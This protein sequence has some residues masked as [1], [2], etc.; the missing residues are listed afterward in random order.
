M[1]AVG[2]KEQ[3]VVVD[4]SKFAH[5]EL[6]SGACSRSALVRRST[7]NGYWEDGWRG[8]MDLLDLVEIRKVKAACIEFIAESE[9][10]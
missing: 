10:G 9:V 6:A 3:D 5:I 7:V 4:R 2:A 1:K 8:V